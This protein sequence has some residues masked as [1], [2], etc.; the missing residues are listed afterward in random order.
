MVV[1]CWGLAFFLVVLLGVQ[2]GAAAQDTHQG[3]L[4]QAEAAYMLRDF[5]TAIALYEGVHDLGYVSSATLYNLGSA[6]YESG[7]LGY[8]LVNFLRAQARSP[9]DALIS[10]GIGLVRSERIDVQGESVILIDNVASSTV[11]VMALSELSWVVFSQWLLLFVG[12]VIYVIQAKWRVWLRSV[13]LVLMI[14]LVSTGILYGSRLYVSVYRP[15]AVVVSES[16][17]VYS[18]P[19]E[20]YL[21]FYDLSEAAEVR[22]IERQGGWARFVLDDG[23][24][25][26]L[27]LR[28]LE[29]V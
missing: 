9:R 7:A 5:N 14:L 22:V 25:G 16:A 19:G 17:A 29:P 2:G 15:L 26:W 23:R 20:D 1:R 27:P 13:L 28:H 4:Q 3:L 18:G 12:G 10:A 6:Y 8:S 11:G 21:Y 24:Q